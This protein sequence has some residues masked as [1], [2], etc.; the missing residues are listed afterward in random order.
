MIELCPLMSRLKSG[1]W[2]VLGLKLAIFS[3][4]FK[5][6]TSNLFCPVFTMRL[7]AKPNKKSVRPKITSLETENKLLCIAKMEQSTGSVEA[8]KIKEVLVEWGVAEKIIACSFDTTSSN[9]GCCVILQ[10]LLNNHL[11]RHSS[12]F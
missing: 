3:T 2:P 5:I 9:K 11:W 8:E 10:T 1:I 12:K 6:W 7:I 4:F